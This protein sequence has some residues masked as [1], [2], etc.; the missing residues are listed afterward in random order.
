MKHRGVTMVEMLV[1][2]VIFSL[3]SLVVFSFTSWVNKTQEIT[4]WKQSAIDAMRL[5]EIFWEKHFSAATPQIKSL[6]VDSKGVIQLTPDIASKPLKIRSA[7]E[8]DL[9]AK[10]PDGS[11][12]WA[13]WQFQTFKKLS[14]GNSFEEYQVTGFLRGKA[15]DISLF[16]RIKK[17]AKVVLEQKLLFDVSSI[18]STVRS[19]P[20][21]NVSVISFEFAIKHP[22]KPEMVVR[23]RSQFKI[24]TD[25]ENL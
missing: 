21:E 16:G 10:Y 18:S 22:R 8:G 7:G 3:V 2:V 5:N 24:A 25:I 6:V 14:T 23:G 15:P 1:V 17:G 13:V 19:Y 20:G 9:M 4:S 12:E 11:K